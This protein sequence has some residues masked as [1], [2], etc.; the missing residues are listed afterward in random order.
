M[1]ESTSNIVAKKPRA[2]TDEA[3]TKST[4][5]ETT[6]KDTTAIIVHTTS[7]RHTTINFAPLEVVTKAKV[8]EMIG[9]AMH[10]FAEK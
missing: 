8:K 5:H 1:A 4:S 9:L 2:K 3:L 10:N 6:S 7:S